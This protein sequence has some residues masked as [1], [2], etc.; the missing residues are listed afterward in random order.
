MKISP[1]KDFKEKPTA[2]PITLYEEDELTAKKA[3][4]RLGENA[5]Y[6]TQ[7]YDQSHTDNGQTAVLS[8]EPLST[9][10]ST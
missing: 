9:S 3:K 2:S 8:R 7:G 5:V 10:H 1:P 4:L 6:R